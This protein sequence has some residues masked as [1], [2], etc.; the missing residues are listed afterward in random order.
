VNG[1]KG[2]GWKEIITRKPDAVIRLASLR[3]KRDAFNDARGG[4]G[5]SCYASFSIQGA[6]FQ[7]EN[8]ILTR[9]RSAGRKDEISSA[10]K[11]RAGQARAETL[12]K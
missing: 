9:Q 5:F 3:I 1:A 2:K 10:A 7:T 12:T 4:G 11:K 6:N 8:A